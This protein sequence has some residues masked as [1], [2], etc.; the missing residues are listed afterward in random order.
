MRNIPHRLMNLNICSPTSGAFRE[1]MESLGVV[2]L[3]KVYHWDQLWG[4][5]V[6]PHFQSTLSAFYV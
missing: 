5:L 4:S 1:V 6:L 3:E 2:L